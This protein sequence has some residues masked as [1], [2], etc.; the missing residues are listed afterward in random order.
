MPSYAGTGLPPDLKDGPMWA[1]GMVVV[2]TKS[3]LVHG[4]Q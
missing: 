1:A 4:T 3:E 2:S